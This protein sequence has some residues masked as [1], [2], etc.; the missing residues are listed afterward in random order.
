MHI[1]IIE[2]LKLMRHMTAEHRKIIFGLKHG[3]VA[4]DCGANIGVVSRAMAASGATVYAFEPNPYAFDVCQAKSRKYPSIHLNQK[5]VGIKPDKVKL[6][7]HQEAQK[8]QVAYSQGSSLLSTKT[9]VNPE[10]YC[11]V[12]SVNLADFI[13]GLGKRVNLLKMD[14]EGYEVEVIPHLI[15]SK[16]IDAIDL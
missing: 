12:E 3:Q 1:N 14:I 13:T 16:A 5:A 15:Q 4:I 11:E 8:D 6:Y 7:L 9:N 10:T 2:R